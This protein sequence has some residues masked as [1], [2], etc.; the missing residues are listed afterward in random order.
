MKKYTSWANHIAFIIP[1]HKFF[2]QSGSLSLPTHPTQRPAV[3]IIP[4]VWNAVRV[5]AYPFC[6]SQSLIQIP[7]LTL[8]FDLAVFH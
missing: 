2:T 4:T 8:A 1:K 5:A 6:A 7:S 3:Y